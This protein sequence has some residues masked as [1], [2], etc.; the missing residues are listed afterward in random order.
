MD[1]MN[2]EG[3][4][5][6]G[7]FH[8][9]FAKYAEYD[10]KLADKS[11]AAID[12]IDYI[13][14]NFATVEETK[15]GLE[16]VR[17]ISVIDP[18]LGS[19]W[20]AHCMISDKSGACMVVEFIDGKIVFYDN[21]VG[22]I[23]NNPTFDWHLTNLRNYGFISNNEFEDVEWGDLKIS[24]LAAGSGMLGLPGDF[25]SP[26]RFVRAVVFSQYSRKTKG[27]YDTVQEIFRI[28]DNFNVGA[29]MAEGSDTSSGDQMP[30]STQWTLVNDTKNLIMYYHTMYN[31]RVREINLNDIDF[32]KGDLR[33]IPLDKTEEEDIED[34]TGSLK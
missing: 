3:L 1:G 21:P 14:S 34:V 25:T 24:P 9:G 18:K 6:G 12:C 33:S 31:R 5:A 22:V 16:K 29:H 10:P 4:S 30:S 19:D 28:L 17:V 7:F 26:S 13:L 15:K 2:T 23:T 27:G 20:P 8:N 11:L 32:S